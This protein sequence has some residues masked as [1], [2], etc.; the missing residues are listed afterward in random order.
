MIREL[1]N[2]KYSLSNQNNLSSSINIFSAYP[3]KDKV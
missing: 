3:K 1:L 2:R